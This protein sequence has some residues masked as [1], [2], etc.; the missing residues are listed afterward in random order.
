MPWCDTCDE[1]RA[2]TALNA[3]GCCDICEQSVDIT[4]LKNPAPTKAPWH[5]WVMVLA[6]VAYLGWRLLQAAIWLAG[7]F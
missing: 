7:H 3:D 1:Y 5:F 6:L 2:P 4:D